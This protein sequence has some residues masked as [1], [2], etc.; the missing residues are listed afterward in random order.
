M[1]TPN[2][3]IPQRSPTANGCPGLFTMIDTGPLNRIR[4]ADRLV[5][6]DLLPSQALTA[7]QR[8]RPHAVSPSRAGDRASGRSGLRIDEPRGGHQV[9]RPRAGGSARRW[10]R[11]HERERHGRV[12]DEHG[13]WWSRPRR[14]WRNGSGRW[15]G[16]FRTERLCLA[17]RGS[18]SEPLAD[19]GGLRAQQRRSAQRISRLRS[20]HPYGERHHRRCER[21]LLGT[22]HPRKPRAKDGVREPAAC[23]VPEPRYIG[24]SGARARRLGWSSRLARSRSARGG[25]RHQSEQQRSWQP[26]AQR[27]APGVRRERVPDRRGQLQRR[28]RRPLQGGC[29]RGRAG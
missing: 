8:P 19:G 18:R 7:P 14:G 15:R 20:H 24:C 4:P 17:R 29:D 5:D 27:G 1:D 21:K 10:P 11:R 22:G 3:T 2:D 12:D 25:R 28:A 9:R 16:R 6:D 26:G 13:G 23:D